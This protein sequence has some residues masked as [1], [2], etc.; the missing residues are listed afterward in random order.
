MQRNPLFSVQSDPTSEK[1]VIPDI[2]NKIF[3]YTG[4]K[5]HVTS[6]KPTDV[7]EILKPFGLLLLM[8]HVEK[9]SV[10]DYRATNELTAPPIFRNPMTHDRLIQLLKL[11][12]WEG[13]SKKE[14]KGAPVYARL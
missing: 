1:I 6:L 14:E 13:N 2:R 7:D 11:L 9:N 5:W 12:H 8:G 10:M 4:K 3:Y